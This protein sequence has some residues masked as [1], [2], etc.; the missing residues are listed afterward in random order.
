[1]LND[2][3]L[4]QA[5]L[6][7]PDRAAPKDA[8]AWIAR[9]TNEPTTLFYI[10][11]DENDD[12]CGFTQVT[13]IHF[14]GRFGWFG[15]AL[16]PEKRAKGL[17]RWALNETIAHAKA[18]HNL[19]KFLLEVAVDNAAAI[20]LYRSEGFRDVGTLHEH[21]DDGVQRRDVLVMERLFEADRA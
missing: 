21:Y 11:A 1:M 15:I 9:R 18:A 16:H 12:V 8:Q 13:N 6:A 17:G 5:L 4:Q 2:F 20:A 14:R 3:D 19:H 10:V 7:Y